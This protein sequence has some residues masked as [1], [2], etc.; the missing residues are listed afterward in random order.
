MAL[1]P[2]AESTLLGIPVIILTA[3]ITLVGLGFLA[4]VLYKRL[5]PIIMLAAPDQRFGLGGVLLMGN[6]AGP[7]FCRSAPIGQ[8][9]EKKQ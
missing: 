9:R 8:N 7:A 2:P 1:I 4:F 3:I 5:Q 6:F